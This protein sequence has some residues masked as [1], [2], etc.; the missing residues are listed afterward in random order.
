VLSTIRACVHVASNYDLRK[1]NLHER[2]LYSVWPFYQEIVGNCM[3]NY[4]CE[5]ILEL[6]TIHQYTGYYLDAGFDVEESLFSVLGRSGSLGQ[7]L[8]ASSSLYCVTPLS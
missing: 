5:T 3:W 4:L 7:C 1:Y 8:V 2:P 6:V